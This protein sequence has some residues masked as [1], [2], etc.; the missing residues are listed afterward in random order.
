[1]ENKGN[2]IIDPGSSSSLYKKM[3]AIICRKYGP[4]EVLQFKEVAKPTLEDN[5]V[6]IRIYA[7]VVTPED[8]FT[9]K[10]DPFLLF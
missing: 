2:E 1:M 6:L 7:G 10:G 8:C 9:R 4:P 5:E 3:K